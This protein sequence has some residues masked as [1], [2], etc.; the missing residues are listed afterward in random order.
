V[1]AKVD[2]YLDD[3]DDGRDVENESDENED[4]LQ[5]LGMG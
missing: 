1:I 3:E 2:N 5:V 4:E